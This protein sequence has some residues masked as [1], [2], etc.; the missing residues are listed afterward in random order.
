V[1]HLNADIKADTKAK[2]WLPT[3]DNLRNFLLMPTAEMLSFFDEGDAVRR[4][5]LGCGTWLPLILISQ[6]LPKATHYCSQPV[7]DK[8]DE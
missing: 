4:M 7:E 8:G 1:Q 2:K 5:P 3:V 6:P